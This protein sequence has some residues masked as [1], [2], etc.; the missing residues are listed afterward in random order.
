MAFILNPTE[1]NL[2]ICKNAILSSN[3][4]SFPTETV[5]GLGASVFDQQALEKIFHAK[6]RPKSDPLIVHCPSVEDVLKITIMNEHQLRVF[7]A[8]STYFWPG[9]LTLI[10]PATEKIS[11]LVTAGG[12]DVGVR[13][14]SNRIALELLRQVD[15]PLAAPSANRFGHVSPTTAQHVYDDL[16]DYPGLLILESNESCPVGIESTVAKIFTSGDVSILRQGAISSLDL[17]K[18]LS[19]EGLENKVELS[20]PSYLNLDQTKGMAAPGQLLT[21]YSPYLESF[22]LTNGKSDKETDIEKILLKSVVIDFQ[23]KY[24]KLKSKALNYFDLSFDGDEIKA[25]QSLFSILRQAEK[26]KDAKYI[27]ISDIGAK[28]SEM[29]QALFDRIY[30]ATSGKYLYINDEILT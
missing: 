26:V 28:N 8:L 21:H 24:V 7:N 3:L 27:L 12:K 23:Q 14:P 30:R 6:G 11:P 20:K 22:I 29:K 25:C 9:P 15:V 16:G 13:I 10:V 1:E 17:I 18:R 5:Y 19:S 2:Q 4:V